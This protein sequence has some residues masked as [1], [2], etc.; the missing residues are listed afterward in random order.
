MEAAGA[1]ELN[2]E[3]GMRE[4]EKIP[5]AGV[6]ELRRNVMFDPGSYQQP[7]GD[8]S[9]HYGENSGDPRY[10]GLDGRVLTSGLGRNKSDRLVWRQQETRLAEKYFEDLRA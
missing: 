4:S 2:K 9:H 8:D 6:P 3:G 5:E 1:G 7:R 10:Y